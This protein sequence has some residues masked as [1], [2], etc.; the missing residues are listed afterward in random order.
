MSLNAMSPIERAEAKLKTLQGVEQEGAP[1]AEVKEPIQKEKEGPAEDE[2]QPETQEAETEKTVEGEELAEEEPQAEEDPN[3]ESY[4][5]KW[6]SLDGMLRSRDEQIKVLN[7]Q[8]DLLSQR[9]EMAESQAQKQTD[10]DGIAVPQA[11][12]KEELHNHL[13]SLAEEYGEEFTSILSKAIREEAAKIVEENL[14]PIKEQVTETAKDSETVRRERFEDTLTDAVPDWRQIY[15]TQEFKSY[16]GDQVEQFSGKTYAELFVE[17]NNAWDMD[18]IV[19]FFNTYKQATGKA[20]KKTQRS[21]DPREK[22]LSPGQTNSSAA[23]RTTEVEGDAKIWSWAE[24]KQFYKDVQT[25]K[26]RGREQEAAQI[27][28]DI[29]MANREGRIR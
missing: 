15:G 28:R 11:A 6:K 2:S 17:A 4:K 1:E 10:E 16:L 13:Q 9:L 14:A 24:A 19:R 7:Q 18:R 23:T 8:I 25:G 29:S 3:S 5:Q 26:Y 20:Q 22:L 27:D 12:T 21:A